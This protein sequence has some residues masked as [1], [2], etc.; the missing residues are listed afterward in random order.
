LDLPDKNRTSDQQ[1]RAFLKQEG[2]IIITKDR[3]FLDSHLL[4]GSPMK[5]ILVKTGNLPNTELVKIFERHFG[6][7]A[8]LMES[9]ALL[10]VSQTEIICQKG[11]GF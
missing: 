11:F 10:E 1:I 6:Q 5:L 4:S 8:D 3:D 2:R 7:I 9:H